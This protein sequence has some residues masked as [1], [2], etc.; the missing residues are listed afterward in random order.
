MSAW[1]YFIDSSSTG[2]TSGTIGSYTTTSSGTTDSYSVRYRTT[3]DALTAAAERIERRE[4]QDDELIRRF[5]EWAEQ[6]VRRSAI[7]NDNENIN[8]IEDDEYSYFDRLGI[9]DE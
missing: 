2:W 5:R 4:R 3:L 8:M 7:M 1:D 6:G 9:G